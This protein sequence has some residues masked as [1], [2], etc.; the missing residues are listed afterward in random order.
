MVVWTNLKRV[1]YGFYFEITAAPMTDVIEDYARSRRKETE[2]QNLCSAG[3]QRKN[4]EGT[5]NVTAVYS[6]GG[7]DSPGTLPPVCT[8]VVS[9]YL[10][11]S[12]PHMPSA[13][14]TLVEQ[15]CLAVCLCGIISLK[16]VEIA[17]PQASL[18]NQSTM[19]QVIVVRIVL[20]RNC[21]LKKV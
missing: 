2:R 3:E 13:P 14:V 5:S 15:P 21:K 12:F 9:S 8:F 11:M 18:V 10:S 16:F 6:A 20:L 17:T 1:H 19:M 7:G 4:L